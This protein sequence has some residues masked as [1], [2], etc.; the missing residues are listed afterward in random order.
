MKLRVG[1]LDDLKKLNFDKIIVTSIQPAKDVVKKIIAVGVP[2]Y[3]VLLLDPLTTAINDNASGK[4]LQP[5]PEEP[6]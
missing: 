5:A 1:K 2:E 4:N 6:A 3:K